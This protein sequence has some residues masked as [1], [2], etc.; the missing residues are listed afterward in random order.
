MTNWIYFVT[1]QILTNGF[2]LCN[3]SLTITVSCLRH[4]TL[5][6][7]LLR[8]RL[9]IKSTKRLFV[10]ILISSLLRS[11][12]LLV[13]RIFP[14]FQRSMTATTK[15]LSIFLLQK[16]TKFSTHLCLKK[17]KSWTR[18][19]KVVATNLVINVVIMILQ[20]AQIQK[21]E[22]HQKCKKK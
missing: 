15:S 16:I 4:R 2:S 3:P 11:L 5:K 13:K 10:P 1:S 17:I 8:S 14:S 22:M 7:T 18:K 9:S 21:V 6:R 20:L 12:V 19:L